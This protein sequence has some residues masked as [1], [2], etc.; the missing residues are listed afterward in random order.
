V[1]D[2]TVA[3]RIPV[4]I[5]LGIFLLI[6]FAPLVSPARDAQFLSN[7]SWGFD[8]SHSID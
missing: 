3:K 2:E 6:S 4:S 5:Q 1:A 8:R 7:T